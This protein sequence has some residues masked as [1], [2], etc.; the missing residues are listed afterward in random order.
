MSEYSPVVR[1]AEVDVDQEVELAARDLVAPDHFRGAFIGRQ[2]L[3]QRAVVLRPE[4][5]AQ[6]VLLALAR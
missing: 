1:H 2:G 6:E 5:V 4:Q 3:G